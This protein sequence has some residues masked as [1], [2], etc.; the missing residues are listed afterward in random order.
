MVVLTFREHASRLERL[1]LT[2]EPR[3]LR[4]HPGVIQGRHDALKLTARFVRIFERVDQRRHGWRSACF[5]VGNQRTESS[6][7]LPAH[8][9]RARSTIRTF[10]WEDSRNFQGEVTV[11]PVCFTTS[12]AK[13]KAGRSSPG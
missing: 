9:H 11:G 4:A 7:G 2:V 1:D 12:K 3:V 5:I 10:I 8:Q 13:W 6:N